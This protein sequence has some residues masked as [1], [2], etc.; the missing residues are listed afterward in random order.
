M[1]T[2]TTQSYRHLSVIGQHILTWPQ[3]HS[4]NGTYMYNHQ[5][6]IHLFKVDTFPCIKG[7]LLKVCFNCPVKQLKPE[8]LHLLTTAP[9]RFFRANANNYEINNVTKHNMVKNSK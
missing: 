8:I 6:S 2:V 3:P 9:M 5:V 7:C 4:N 1:E